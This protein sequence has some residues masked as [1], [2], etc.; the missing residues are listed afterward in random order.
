MWS[1]DLHPQRVTAVGLP[2]EL[3][4]LAR[5]YRV[6][7]VWLEDRENGEAGWFT[8][9]ERRKRAVRAAARGEP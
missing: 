7:S 4:G 1:R 6:V 5:D 8:F 2:R 9:L 3:A